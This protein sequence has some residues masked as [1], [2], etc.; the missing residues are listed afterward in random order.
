MTYYQPSSM[1]RRLF[2]LLCL[3]YIPE[4]PKMKTSF[5]PFISDFYSKALYKS[6]ILA[7]EIVCSVG[8]IS[9]S[10][11]EIALSDCAPLFSE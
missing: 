5:F 1:V 4:L 8:G 10:N 7:L 11:H 6:F 2:L 3:F 9:L